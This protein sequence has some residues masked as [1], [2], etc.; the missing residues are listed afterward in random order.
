MPGP[1]AN[2]FTLVRL[3]LV[4]AFLWLYVTFLGVDWRLDWTIFLGLAKWFFIDSIHVFVIL[5]ELRLK[6]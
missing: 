3:V 2:A 5:F 6:S 1:I 4:L